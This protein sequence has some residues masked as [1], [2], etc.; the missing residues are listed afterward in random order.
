MDT[1]DQPDRSRLIID[2]NP[3]LRHRLELAAEQKD[4]SLREYVE[5]LLER[6]ASYDTNNAQQRRPMSSETFQ[7]LLR[8]REQ[9]KHNHP[10]QVFDDST[11]I[12]RQMREERSR[13]LADL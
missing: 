3:D 7:E 13:Y 4:T 2:I 8:L 9:I 6:I 5:E 1:Q 12:I 10:G 11:E